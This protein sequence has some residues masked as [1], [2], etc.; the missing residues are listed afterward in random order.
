MKS[1]LMVVSVL[2]TILLGSDMK[3]PRRNMQAVNQTPY[4]GYNGPLRESKGK[5]ILERGKRKSVGNEGELQD[6]DHLMEMLNINLRDRM[7]R[8]KDKPKKVDIRKRKD[9]MQGLFGGRR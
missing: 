8:E 7:D 3:D 6:I 9:R 1:W 4:P 2:F 5:T